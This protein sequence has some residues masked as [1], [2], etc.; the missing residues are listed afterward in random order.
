MSTLASKAAGSFTPRLTSAD[1]KPAA[2]GLGMHRIVMRS[3][4]RKYVIAD[5]ALKHVQVHTLAF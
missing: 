3:E 1:A 5:S 4:G 2:K